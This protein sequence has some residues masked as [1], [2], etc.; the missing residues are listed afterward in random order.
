MAG[1]TLDLE[2][3]GA[4]ASS[5]AA[6]AAGREVILLVFDSRHIRWAHNLLLNLRSLS[7]SSRALAIGP[8][9]EACDALLG[10][11]PS[12]GCARSSYLRSGHNATIDAALRRW[13]FGPGH[14]YHLWWQRWRYMAR[15][16]ELGCGT[17]APLR[18]ETPR[19]F[20]E[21]EH[22]RTRILF[23]CQVLGALARL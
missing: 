1:D 16:V 3:P 18:S 13:S 4:L 5:L 8:D 23:R 22:V 21:V 9:T 10:R 6:R 15:A 11:V 20:R 14:V 7:L 2:A 19:W 12:A 17:R